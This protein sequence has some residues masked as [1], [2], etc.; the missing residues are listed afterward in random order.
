[1]RRGYCA[2]I[3]GG[4]AAGTVRE[5]VDLQR[6]VE[7]DAHHRKFDGGRVRLRLGEAGA[8]GQRE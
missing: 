5:D 2:A 7:A 4:Y 6:L 1:M 8:S 3:R